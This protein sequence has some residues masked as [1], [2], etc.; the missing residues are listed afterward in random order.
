MLCNCVSS[1]DGS[2]TTHVFK[3]IRKHLSASIILKFSLTYEGLEPSPLPGPGLL[4]DRHDLEHLVLEG[5]TD[6]GVDDLMLL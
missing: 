1:L 2:S 3:V 5:R 4:L 6:E